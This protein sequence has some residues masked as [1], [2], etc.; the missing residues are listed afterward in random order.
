LQFWIL[1]NSNL[2]ESVN[3]YFRSDLL[4]CFCQSLISAICNKKSLVLRNTVQ[5]LHVYKDFLRAS[6]AL[7]ITIFLVFGRLFQIWPWWYLSVTW[8]L[9]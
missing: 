1:P 7:T 5:H 8:S 2:E 6:W 3:L 9:C 4:Q